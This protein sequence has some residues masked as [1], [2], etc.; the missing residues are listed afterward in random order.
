MDAIFIVN[1]YGKV[2]SMKRILTIALAVLLAAAFVQAGIPVQDMGLKVLGA[3]YSAAMRGATITDAVV[4]SHERFQL[5]MIHYAPVPYALI[6]CGAGGS[7]F[8]VNEYRQTSFDGNYGLTPAFGL[9]L[10]T[11]RFAKHAVSITVGI[12]TL[13]LN[14]PGDHA[15]RYRGFVVNP[16]GGL[17]LSLGRFVDWEL[18][19]M[20]HFIYGTTDNDG[21]ETRFSNNEIVRG[22]TEI[23]LHDAA[24][25]VFLTGHF[26]ASPEVGTDWS[27]GPSEAT[28]GLSVGIMLSPDREYRATEDRNSRWFPRLKKMREEQ[29]KMVDEI[30]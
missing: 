13:Y 2:F 8:S 22:Y 24:L 29:K 12:K 27:Q 7:R 3:E 14:S 9:A 19:A 11:P 5:F 10:F 21:E 30:K 25:G 15:I 1:E 4:P 17:K 18:G 6:S 23:T 16:S 20:G 28:L 26:D